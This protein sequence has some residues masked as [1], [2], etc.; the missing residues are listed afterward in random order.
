MGKIKKF[1][2]AFADSAA[3][4]T[5]ELLENLWGEIGDMPSLPSSLPLKPQDD[6]EEPPSSTKKPITNSSDKISTLDSRFQPMVRNFLEA[7]AQKG[8]RIKITEGY[9]S[10]E[11]QEELYAQ[12]RTKPGPIV[13]HAKPGSSLH[14]FGLAID[15][16]AVDEN[17]KVSWPN[18]VKYWKTLGDIGRSV[19]LK[20]GGDFPSAQ[21]DLPHFQYPIRMADIYTGSFKPEKT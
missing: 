6:E 18:E 20:W 14:N 8:I 10:N 13:T 1:A 4:E 21:T 12:G 9:R 17:G 16:A 19:G 3:N 5:K 7:V 15:V 11:R 2:D